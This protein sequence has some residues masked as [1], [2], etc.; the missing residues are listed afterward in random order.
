MVK[1]RVEHLTK[2]F[3]KKPKEILNRLKN[4]SKEKIFPETGGTVELKMPIF[5]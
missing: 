4:Q 2:V 3:G 1:I 5:Q